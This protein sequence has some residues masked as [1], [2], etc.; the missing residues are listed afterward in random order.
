MITGINES[1]TLT[2]DIS[3]E[4]KCTF[5]ETKFKSNQWRNNDKCQCECRKD[6]ICEKEYVWNSSACIYKSGK[7]LASIMDD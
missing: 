7:D 3:C 2:K 1:E 5:D 4:C 6:H